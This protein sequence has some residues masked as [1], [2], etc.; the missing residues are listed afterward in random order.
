MANVAKMIL[1]ANDV[2]S[3]ANDGEA[4]GAMFPCDVWG[5]VCVGP[6]ELLLN[7]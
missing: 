7:F 2:G 3:A 1:R 5:E 6:I 4:L